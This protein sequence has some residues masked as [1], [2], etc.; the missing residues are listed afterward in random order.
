MYEYH[1]YHERRIKN[2][3]HLRY[4]VNLTQKNNSI[5]TVKNTTWKHPTIS[6]NP[7]IAIQ[8]L[9]DH[10][11]LTHIILQYQ[12]IRVLSHHFSSV[13]LK[14]KD[15]YYLINTRRC[16]MVIVFPISLWR[17]IRRSFRLL[18]MCRKVFYCFYG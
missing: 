10:L 1:L 17:R 11:I 15:K 9:I 3:N 6:T 5:P 7:K 8:L 14:K 16:I 18:I 13:I 4:P 12:L 2:L